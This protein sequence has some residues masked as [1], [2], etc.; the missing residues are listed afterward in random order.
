MKLIEYLETDFN[1]CVWK[2]P[3]GFII[4]KMKAVQSGNQ[5]S[6]LRRVVKA[7]LRSKRNN[8]D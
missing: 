5:K 2:L 3:N 8:K 4:P 7:Y 1:R 6:Y